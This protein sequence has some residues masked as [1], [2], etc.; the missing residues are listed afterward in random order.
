M[1]EIVTHLAF[2]EAA[3]KAVQFYTSI[4]PDARITGIT[5]FR[6]GE[7]GPEGTVRT[8]RF[9][10]LGQKFLAVNGGPEFSFTEGISLLVRCDTQDEID[11]LWKRLGDGGQPQVCGWLTDRYG[12]SWQIVPAVTEEYMYGPDPEA[13]QR[14]VEATYKMTKINLA[15]LEDAYHA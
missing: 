13:A 6:A 14:V 5:H 4:F 15:E 3:E 11:R 1:K 7:P 9:E 10:M 8:V 12:L 2:K